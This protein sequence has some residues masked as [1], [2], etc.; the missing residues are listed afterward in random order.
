MGKTLTGRHVFLLTLAFFS[1]TLAV[2]G[3]LV[4]FAVGTFSGEDAKRSYLQGLHF[5]EALA[6]RT[7]QRALAWEATVNVQ[8]TAPDRVV[9]AYRLQRASGQPVT[10]VRLKGT[11]QLPA[12]SDADRTFTFLEVAPG[13]YRAE[14]SAVRAAY[15]DL[16]VTG[17]RPDIDTAFETRNRLWIP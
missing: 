7:A 13:A 1:I 16:V 5:N 10:G 17:S 8:R 3:M 6:A 12:T 4:A 14:I 2:N 15:W 11:L 9:I